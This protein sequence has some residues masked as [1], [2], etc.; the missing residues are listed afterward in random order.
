MAPTN[1]SQSET[2]KRRR[3][4]PA[5]ELALQPW[6]RAT[7]LTRCSLYWIGVRTFPMPSAQR[8]WLLA[9]MTQIADHLQ[10]KAGLRHELFIE[11][12]ALSPSIRDTFLSKSRDWLP[13]T[14]LCRAPNAPLPP[15]PSEADIKALQE[16][17]KKFDA[18]EYMPDYGY[19]FLDSSF[20]PQM[21]ALFGGG[22]ATVLFLKPDTKTQPTKLTLPK[23]LCQNP[24]YAGTDPNS[25]IPLPSF[26]RENPLMRQLNV[27][28]KINAAFKLQDEFLARSKTIFGAGLESSPAYPGFAFIIP[29]LES[30]DFFQQPEADV[31][32]WFELFDVYLHESKP[33]QGILLAAREDIDGPISE[34]VQ[35]M[36]EEGLQYPNG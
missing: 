24:L 15:L 20:Q 3:L 29:S 12:K 34:I 25:A 31:K 23:E 27:E 6:R 33:D 11:L 8:A 35:K 28:S 14:G 32:K 10:E 13:L 5:D 2:E 30:K 36:K 19:W 17:K 18:N 22:A 1:T 21:D 26:V 7:E 9:F 16:G 4:A